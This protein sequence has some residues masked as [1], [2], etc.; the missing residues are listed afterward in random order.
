MYSQTL[1]FAADQRRLPPRHDLAKVG[2]LARRTQC[3]RM[4]RPD[5]EKAVFFKKKIS[6][7]FCA[8]GDD[9]NAQN[10]GK[11]GIVDSSCMLELNNHQNMKKKHFRNFFL[12]FS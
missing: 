9:K 1:I 2:E 12:N 7:V 8:G 6:G 4:F 11:N 10:I 5:W 3:H